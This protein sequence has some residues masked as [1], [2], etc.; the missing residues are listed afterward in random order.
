MWIFSELQIHF[1]NHTV[2]V[3]L[4]PL[5]GRK[6]LFDANKLCPVNSTDQLVEVLGTIKNH[7]SSAAMST[8]FSLSASPYTLVQQGIKL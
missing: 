3:M 5:M 1:S 2:S 4:Q 8:I 7:I 6:S